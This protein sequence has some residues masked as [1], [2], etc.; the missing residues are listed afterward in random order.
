MSNS[1]SADAR[2]GDEVDRISHG[3]PN[4]HIETH[5]SRTSRLPWALN[6]GRSGRV[7]VSAAWPAGL[8]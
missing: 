2:L 3:T 5:V 4:S 1:N 8:C 7:V 6:G